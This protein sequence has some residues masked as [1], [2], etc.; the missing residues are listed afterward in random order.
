MAVTPAGVVTVTF[1]RPPASGGATAVICVG[2]LTVKLAAGIVPKSTI[3]APLRLVPVMTTE[4]PPAVGPAPGL[5][6]VTVE[7]RVRSSRGSRKSLDAEARRGHFRRR[8]CLAGLPS[9]WN[10]RDRSQ[11]KK[12]MGRLFFGEWR[13]VH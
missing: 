9:S 8:F 7:G 13:A 11:V 5:T 10:C 4:V 2:E 3:V 12:D 6:F 1:T